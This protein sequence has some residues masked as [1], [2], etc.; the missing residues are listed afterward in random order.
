MERG[1]DVDELEDV[2]LLG[3]TIGGV[4]VLAEDVHRRGSILDS[5]SSV[6]LDG[7]S[8][9]A[10][11]FSLGGAESESKTLVMEAELGRGIFFFLLLGGIDHGKEC[12]D[13]KRNECYM[14]V[15]SRG[16]KESGR[17]M[18]CVGEAQRKSVVTH[19]LVVSRQLRAPS[20]HCG[21]LRLATL[22]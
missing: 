18:E 13:L 12:V 5:S 14:C 1:F 10:G 15:K 8:D 9:G 22:D 16:A 3:C 2:T 6:E 11:E 17:E 20:S 7:K 19:D 4:D 21:S